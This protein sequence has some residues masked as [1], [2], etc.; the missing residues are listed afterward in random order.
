MLVDSPLPGPVLGFRFG[1]FFFVGGLL[2][3]PID[4]RFQRVSGL[5]ST[6][7]VRKLAEGGENLYSHSLPVSVDH[8]NLVLERGLMVGSPLNIEF[9]VAL[10][11]FKFYPSNVMVTV[12]NEKKVPLAGWLFTKAFPV[13]WATSTLDAG[14]NEVAIDT[15]ELAYARMQ[16]IRI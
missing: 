6:I 7:Q 10:T 12:F 3:N 4:I 11:M 1:V 9:N 5:E 13:R 8:G 16:M 14:R 15:M 2:P